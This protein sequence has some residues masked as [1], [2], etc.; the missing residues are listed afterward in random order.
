ME[1][2]RTS[3]KKARKNRVGGNGRLLDAS[4][5]VVVSDESRESSRRFAGACK[6]LLSMRTGALTEHLVCNLAA[7]EESLF[8]FVF[9]RAPPG[10]TA[11]SGKCGVRVEG[12]HFI[13]AMVGS[14]Q[15]NSDVAHVFSVVLEYPQQI[16]PQRGSGRSHLF[17]RALCFAFRD[18]YGMCVSCWNCWS[19]PCC[20]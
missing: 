5:V 9:E 7:K 19:P 14:A 8:V 18:S 3:K 10:S 11:D 4:H 13:A 2:E 6:V 15:R 20:T 16:P 12:Q 17:S 1:R